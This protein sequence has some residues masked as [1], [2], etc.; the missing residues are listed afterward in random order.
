[1]RR[2]KAKCQIKHAKRRAV[3]RFDIS[4][5][6]DDI[7]EMIREIQNSQAR[8]VLKQSH[9]VSLFEVTAKGKQLIAVYDRQRK[10]IVTFLTKDMS[11]GESD[12]R[13]AR[14]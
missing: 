8:F 9:R 1:M 4:L 3:Q 6:Q 2:D 14:D 5:S 13:Q 12:D 7:Q 11:L 10:T